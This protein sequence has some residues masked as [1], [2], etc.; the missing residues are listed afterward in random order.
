MTNDDQGSDNGLW[1]TVKETVSRRKF[2]SGGVAAAGVTAVGAAYM[3]SADDDPVKIVL[4][5]ADA[6][7]VQD[8]GD[9]YVLVNGWI[10]PADDVRQ[11]RK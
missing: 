10:L 11:E 1:V 6:D 9:G 4:R 2:L 3:F 8:V 5:R 7:D